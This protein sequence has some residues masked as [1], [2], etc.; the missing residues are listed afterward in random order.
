MGYGYFCFRC[1]YFGFKQAVPVW[2]ACVHFDTNRILIDV[3][4]S[5][6]KMTVP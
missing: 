5:M 4:A 2:I 6:H 1:T 3:R